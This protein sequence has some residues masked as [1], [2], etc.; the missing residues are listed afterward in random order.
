MIAVRSQ[1]RDQKCI[2]VTEQALRVE[3]ASRPLPLLSKH[4]CGFTFVEI[5]ACLVFLGILVPTIIEGISLANRASV[6]AERGATAVAL[7]ENKIGELMLDNTLATGET[8]GDFGKGW[9][10]YRWESSQSTW[11]LDNLT[12]L[13]VDVFYKV[14]GTERSA[15]LS[16]LMGQTTTQTSGT[17][18]RTSTGG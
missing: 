9:P 6:I 14:Q 10:D 1:E 8:S 2:A 3:R 11:E 7:A 15:R 16:T 17:Q 4:S 18:T 13:Q 12:V 5:L